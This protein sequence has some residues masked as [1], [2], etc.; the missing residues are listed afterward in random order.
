MKK[1]LLSILLIFIALSSCTLNPKS[2]EVLFKDKISDSIVS[3][4]NTKY[5]TN[6]VDVRNRTE[7]SGGI[8][9]NAEWLF[10][11]PNN[12]IDQVYDFYGLYNYNSG[13]MTIKVE[14][15]S[16]YFAEKG[17]KDTSDVKTDY[18]II[19]QE[20]NDLLKFQVASKE[21]LIFSTVKFS[22]VNVSYTGMNWMT[23]K[24]VER[25]K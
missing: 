19:K 13:Y 10:Y 21:N 8:Y 17:S 11:L 16:Y 1:G 18:F 5:H 24:V 25:K 14:I 3:E 6:F 12:G 4:L 22:Y 23:I 2:K 15:E 20:D 9:P 7:L